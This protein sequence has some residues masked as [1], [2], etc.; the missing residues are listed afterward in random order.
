MTP[1]ER[2]EERL[3]AYL[4]GELTPD[5]RS[6]VEAE[7]AASAETREVLDDLRLVRS[8]LAALDDVR[9]PRSFALTAPPA[10]V[11]GGGLMRRLEMFIRA[12]AAGAAL[13][14]FVA[15]V[16]Q[17]TSTLSTSTRMGEADSI[18]PG[19]MEMLT[20][21][22]AES[23]G[24]ASGGG[25]GGGTTQSDGGQAGGAGVDSAARPEPAN[26]EAMPGTLMM[27]PMPAP[28][29]PV[30]DEAGRGVPNAAPDVARTAGS[31]QAEDAGTTA[32]LPASQGIGGVVP[33][34]AALTVLLGLLSVLI[35]WPRG[36]DQLGR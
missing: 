2:L 12:S 29:A 33:A 28:D 6:A 9:A 7:L 36:R 18:A 4:D 20:T 34:L 8:A 19:S 25:F 24:P 22:G 27:P 14:F 5:E 31:G 21:A 16:Y 35:A 15:V 13:L 10:R 30:T 23:T 17:P 26:P 3:S 1:L 11:A 32:A